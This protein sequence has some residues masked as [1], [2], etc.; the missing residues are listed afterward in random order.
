MD[1]RHNFRHLCHSW[2]TIPQ[3]NMQNLRKKNIVTSS[4]KELK[5]RQRADQSKDKPRSHNSRTVYLYVFH[6]DRDTLTWEGFFCFASF[7]IQIRPGSSLLWLLC[8][9]SFKG[10]LSE[11]A[12]QSAG[13]RRVSLKSV[14]I[15]RGYQSLGSDLGEPMVS[16]PWQCF[17]QSAGDWHR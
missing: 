1:S 5:K 13:V 17:S 16:G 11:M 8:A 9:R 7:L 14:T 4:H 12:Q 10:L 6:F 15:I 3:Q 2:H